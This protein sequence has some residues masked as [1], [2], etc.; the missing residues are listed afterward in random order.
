LSQASFDAWVKYYR[1]D[2]NTPN[3]TVSYYSKGALVALCLDL[4]LRQERAAT[5]D[6]VMR[7]LWA[8]C[9][10]GPMSEEDL[11]AVLNQLAGR[12][13]S[14]ELSQWVHGTSDLP[15]ARLLSQQGV[16]VHEAEAPLARRFGIRVSDSGPLKIKTVLRGSAAEQAGFAAGDEWLAIE[17]GR[18]RAAS[19]WRINRLED[20]LLYLGKRRRVQAWVSRDMRML[21]LNLVLPPSA[22]TVRL[23]VSDRQRASQWLSDR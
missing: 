23:E 22:R 20:L 9:K 18:G 12:S 6:A 13:F 10:G 11:S 7:A 4:T 16:A 21:R 2:E 1:Q 14:G 15:V 5:L 3:A 19:M 17:V 8:R